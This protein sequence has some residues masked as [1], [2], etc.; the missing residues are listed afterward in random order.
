MVAA[1]AAPLWASL[2]PDSYRLIGSLCPWLH[3]CPSLTGRIRAFWRYERMQTISF[4]MAFFASARAVH[5]FDV[6]ATKH[7]LR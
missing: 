7:A 6:Q 1:A 3:A 5:A 4:Q 2:G